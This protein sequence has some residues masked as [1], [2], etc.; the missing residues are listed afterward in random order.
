M[1][2]L[3]QKLQTLGTEWELNCP[4]CKHSTFR[5]GGVA[6]LAVFPHSSDQ[7]C[8]TLTLLRGQEIPMR[9][10]GNGSNVVFSDAGYRGVVVFTEK[11]RKIKIEDNILFADAGASLS[12]VA[13]AA[14][15]ENLSGLEFAFGI[16]GTLGGAVYMNAGA[17]GGSMSDVCISSEYYDLQT[18]QRGSLTD[19]EQDFD[20]R[21]SI[22]QSHPERVILNATLQLQKG[23]REQITQTMRTFWDKRRNTQPLELPN[24]GSIFK[25]PKGHFAGK[26]IE[27]C[28][29]KG[30]TVGGAQVSEKHAGFIVN[31]GGATCEDVKC[32]IEQIQ[33]TV[34]QQTGVELECEIQFL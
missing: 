16:P 32:L 29:L 28:G 23:D 18:G 22:Y 10:I 24:A 26:L 30:L 12:A 17:Y 31:V 14:R 2:Q 20:Y 3:M 21:K 13:S 19:G 27:D 4:L 9:I 15:D 8:Q 5:I 34:L 7:L 1:E 33:T 11:C 6:D 25:R